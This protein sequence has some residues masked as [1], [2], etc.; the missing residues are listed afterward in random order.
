MAMNTATDKLREL[1]ALHRDDGDGGYS[2]VGAILQASLTLGADDR[3]LLR[4][5]LIH[6]VSEQDRLLWGVALEALI[7]GWGTE[8]SNELHSLLG[9]RRQDDEWRGHVLF[10]LLRLRYMPVALEGAG[11]IARQL[12][13]G[14]DTILPMLAALCKVDVNACLELTSAFFVN[15]FAKK[16]L[17]ALEGYVPAFVGHFADTDVSLIGTLIR[18]IGEANG[19]A[20]FHVAEMLTR[21]FKKPFV[22]DQLGKAAVDRISGEIQAACSALSRRGRS[23]I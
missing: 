10:A 22:A 14:N 7:Q 12:K 5:E 16:H 21:Y 1:E 4:R 18:K 11:Y 2:L 8:I 19:N 3:T 23:T 9:G 20:A 13:V 6:L 15:C 17:A